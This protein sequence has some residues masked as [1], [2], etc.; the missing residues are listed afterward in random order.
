MNLSI[1]FDDLFEFDTRLSDNQAYL[2]ASHKNS[3]E[4]SSYVSRKISLDDLAVQLRYSMS[5]IKSAA[6][7]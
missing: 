5:N 3:I 1:A 6:Y 7:C 4:D 2:I